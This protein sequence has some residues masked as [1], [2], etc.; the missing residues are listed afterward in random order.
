MKER[1]QVVILK[2]IVYSLIGIIMAGD[3]F[4]IIACHRM[5]QEQDRRK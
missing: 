4:L 3:I 1:K 5:E 2:I